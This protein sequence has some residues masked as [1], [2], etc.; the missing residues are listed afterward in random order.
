MPPSRPQPL[1]TM[2]AMAVVRLG[3]NDYPCLIAHPIGGPPEYVCHVQA[4]C[5]P[6]RFATYLRAPWSEVPTDGA[7]R[8]P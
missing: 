7:W 5:A 6:G 2:G 3:G 1:P 8:W 4:F